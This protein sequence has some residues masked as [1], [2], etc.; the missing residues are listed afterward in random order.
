MSQWK[1]ES[2]SLVKTFVFVSF[3]DAMH[4]MQSAAPF[5]SETD[6]HPTWT[7]TYNRVE[8]KL[9][10]HDEGNK[11][12]EKDKKLAEYLDQLYQV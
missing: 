6:H 11:V 10:T 7:N 2:H 8:I 1:E 4:F 3:E 12:T 9:T 5:I